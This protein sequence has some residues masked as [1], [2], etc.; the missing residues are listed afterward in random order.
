M[1]QENQAPRYPMPESI[2]NPELLVGR[3][4]E[5]TTFNRWIER[6]PDRLSKSRAILARRKSGKTAFLQRLYNRL[7][8]AGG[9]VIPFYIDMGER[10]IWLPSLALTYYRTFVSQFISFLERDEK[11]VSIPLTLE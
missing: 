8:S 1:T 2:G 3:E 6:I 7:W 4:K 9:M 10:R 5:F 11:M